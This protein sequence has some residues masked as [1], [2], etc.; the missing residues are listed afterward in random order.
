MWKSRAKFCAQERWEEVFFLC[1]LLQLEN[2]PAA[3][4]KEHVLSVANTRQVHHGAIH[5]GTVASKGHRGL[6]L[7]I[8][9]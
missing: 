6:I 2:W 7:P 5:L 8:V 9:S 3:Y 4:E 1:V